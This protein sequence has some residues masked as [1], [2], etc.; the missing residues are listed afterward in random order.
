M[1]GGGEKVSPGVCDLPEVCLPTV[2]S[3]GPPSAGAPLPGMVEG[4]FGGQYGRGPPAPRVA[5]GTLVGQAE[6]VQTP[7]GAWGPNAVPASQP[8]IGSLNWSSHR[9][10]CLTRTRSPG[11][12]GTARA[13]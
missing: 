7:R 11:S 3:T 12:K 5:P 2:L 10:K 6:A 9:R 13:R 1:G 4:Y 8:L